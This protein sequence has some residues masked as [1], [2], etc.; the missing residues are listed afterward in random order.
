MFISQAGLAVGP[1]ASG[2]D[3][4]KCRFSGLALACGAGDW[5]RPGSENLLCCL[6][7]AQAFSL[8]KMSGVGIPELGNHTVGQ[9]GKHRAALQAAEM[10]PLEAWELDVFVEK[11]G[12]QAGL[13]EAFLWGKIGKCWIAR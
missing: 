12:F 3:G 6:L 5:G 7:P 4:W 13:E 1:A 2:W 9:C 10:G 8:L 11:C